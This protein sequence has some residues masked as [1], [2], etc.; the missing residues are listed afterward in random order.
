MGFDERIN[1]TFTWN[2]ILSI[3]FA[4]ILVLSYQGVSISQVQAQAVGPTLIEGTISVSEELAGFVVEAIAQAQTEL[5][6]DAD[7]FAITDVSDQRGWLYVSVVGLKNIPRSGDWNILDHGTWFSFV[8]V[9]MQDKTVQDAAVYRTSDF[10][11]L[12]AKSPDIV[13]DPSKKQ[14]LSD[15][16]PQAVISEDYI[17]PFPAGY[18]IHY[19]S[20]GVHSG[21]GDWAVDLGSDGDTTAR[22]APNQLIAAASGTVTYRCSPDDPSEKTGVIR[23]GNFLYAHLVDSTITQNMGESVAQG[24]ILGQLQ[25]GPFDE[26]PCG[27]AYQGDNWFHVHMQFVD[28]PLT[29]GNW[30]L[31]LAEKLDESTWSNGTE[32]KTPYS[33]LFIDPLFPVDLKVN[34]ITYNPS[35]PD[36]GETT[37]ATMQVS[38]IGTQ[39]LSDPFSVDLY[40][41][42]IRVVCGD[43]GDYSVELPG[44]LAGETIDVDFS[45][46]GLEFGTRKINAYVDTNCVVD[47]ADE[48]NEYG[49][50]LL[51]I[52][53]SPYLF[54]DGFETG[55]FSEWYSVNSGGGFI[56]PCTKAAMNG[57]YGACVQRGTNSYR[58]QLVDNSPKKETSLSV[59]FNFDI[60]SLSMGVND[61]LHI[62]KLKKLKEVPAYVVI[63]QD[64]NQYRIKLITKLD[65]LT[66]V[67]SSWITLSDEPHTLEVS[68]Q[69]ASGPGANDG[70]AELYIDGA[71]Q[72]ALTGLDNDTLNITHYGIGFT[73]LLTGLSISG[74]VYID[75]VLTSSNGYIGLP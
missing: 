45:I 72:E 24:T 56:Y 46:A 66:K 25:T 75:D 17:F 35:V 39:D 48:D 30:T 20:L 60:H 58:K 49:P 11:A 70:F 3:V 4:F 65:D 43:L 10:S 61:P 42:R 69:A 44:I 22:H 62:L 13:I 37:L 71:L 63:K 68:W 32:T 41:D 9:Q 31:T 67:K 36:V 64:G 54:Y 55:D 53:P 74:I 7:Y 2:T 47:E 50:D 52:I 28:N 18:N 6:I 15:T 57:T 8:L 14:L 12:A 34:T 1:T 33:W 5:I 73:N 59:Q 21:W 19:G 29:L 40:I 38:N 16:Y 23:V 51:N 27:Y 26:Y